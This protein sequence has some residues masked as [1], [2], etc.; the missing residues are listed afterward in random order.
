MRV[1]AL[2]ALAALVACGGGGEGRAR[3][4]AVPSRAADIAG[5]VTAVDTAWLRVEADPARPTGAP[6]ALL[7]LRPA[8]VVRRAPGDSAAAAA[9]LRAGQFV[10]VWYGG[11]VFETYPVQGDAGVVVIDSAPRAPGAAKPARRGPTVLFPGAEVR[12]RAPRVAA[13]WLRGR[14]VRGAGAAPGA[15]CT[16]IALTGPDARGRILTVPALAEVQADRRTNTATPLYRSG[17]PAPDDW[18]AVPLAAVRAQ[19]AGC[20]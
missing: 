20:R 6:K 14:V 16:G 4:P 11:P 10:R 9:D 2:L 12:V 5:V 8:T 19:D 1:P 7:R 17:E 3:P 15:A 18:V 13:G